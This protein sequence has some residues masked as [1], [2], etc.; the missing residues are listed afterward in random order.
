MAYINSLWLDTL[1][2]WNL[3][4]ASSLKSI[5][6]DEHMFLIA[7]LIT[8]LVYDTVAKIYYSLLIVVVPVRR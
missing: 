2:P 8:F 4:T 6:S 3:S 5:E 7:F 1:Q